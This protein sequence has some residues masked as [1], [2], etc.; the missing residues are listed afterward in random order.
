MARGV[1]SPQRRG[2]RAK[3]RGLTYIRSRSLGVPLSAAGRAALPPAHTRQ[4]DDQGGPSSATTVVHKNKKAQTQTARGGPQ[5]VF[6][7]L[8]SMA[9]RLTQD[10]ITVMGGGGGRGGGPRSVSQLPATAGRRLALLALP[11]LGLA[12]AGAPQT[13]A[14][15]AS[16]GHRRGP[17][18]PSALHPPS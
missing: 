14:A 2:L 12:G 8:F 17:F 3:T 9:L 7:F 6:R 18:G 10:A 15:R 16:G 1:H 5:H 4:G 13:A 11:R